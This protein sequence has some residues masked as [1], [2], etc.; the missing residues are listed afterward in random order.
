MHHPLKW[1]RFQAHYIEIH[2]EY[3]ISYAIIFNAVK[4]RLNSSKL[5]AVGV[6]DYVAGT[7]KKFKLKEKIV[8]IWK[9]L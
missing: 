8:V 1:V 5:V 9:D 7:D 2:L 3:L 4:Y 6:L